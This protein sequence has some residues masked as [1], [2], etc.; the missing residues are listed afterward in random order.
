MWMD[1][2]FASQRPG[3]FAFFKSETATNVPSGSQEIPSTVEYSSFPFL[4]LGK[5]YCR[6][7]PTTVQSLRRSLPSQRRDIRWEATAMRSPWIARAE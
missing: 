5:S 4:V 1:W 6:P 2:S 7:A 3:W